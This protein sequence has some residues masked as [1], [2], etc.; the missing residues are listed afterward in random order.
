M[1]KRRITANEVL[2]NRF[3]QLPKFLI[4]NEEFKKLSSDAK[5][6]YSIMRDRHQLSLQNNWIDNDGYVFLIYSRE[7]MME[8]LQLSDKTITKAVKDLKK[9]GLIDEVRQGQGKPNLIYVMTVSLDYQQNR[10]KYVS[11][12]VK[13]TNL[14]SENLRP[15][16]TKNK[17][18]DMNDNENKQQQHKEVVVVTKTTMLPS[19]DRI[20][21]NEMIN[22]YKNYFDKKP[23]K[24][25]QRQIARFLMNFEND[26]VE[27]ALEMASRKGKD[28]D[29]AIGIINKWQ[30]HE[31]FTIDDIYE[32]DKRYQNIRI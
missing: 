20:I 25:V 32:Y 9:H 3:Y 26:A 13:N 10:K 16:N 14:N 19:T 7:N 17:Q 12:T 30:E 4:H 31:A 11:K 21:S 24:A 23:T 2:E 8:D 5:I 28:F 15:N 18:T 1:Q 22:T 27:M 29:Y 6:L